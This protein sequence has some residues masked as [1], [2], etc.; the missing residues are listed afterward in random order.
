MAWVRMLAIFALSTLAS[1]NEYNCPDECGLYA[2]GDKVNNEII[3]SS[4]IFVNMFINEDW[5]KI[6]SW[7]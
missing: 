1:Y 3:N 2:P 6:T 7:L 5:T 4:C